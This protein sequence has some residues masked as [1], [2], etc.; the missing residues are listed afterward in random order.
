MGD[1]NIGVVRFHEAIKGRVRPLGKKS[2]SIE[3]TAIH[4]LLISSVISPARTLESS[5]LIAFLPTLIKL[6]D[7]SSAVR[8]S[9][10]GHRRRR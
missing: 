8:S 7:E 3:S 10:I 6:T 9:E 5:K 2:S 4:R 1:V